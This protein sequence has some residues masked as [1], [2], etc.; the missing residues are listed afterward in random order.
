QVATRIVHEA[1]ADRH[2]VQIVIEPRAVV[3]HDAEEIC[4][5]RSAGAMNAPAVLAADIPG[6]RE[7][8][9]RH[10]SAIAAVT[11]V[12]LHQYA[13]VLVDA[14]Y[15]GIVDVWRIGVGGS[16]RSVGV[17]AVVRDTAAARQ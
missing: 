13:V 8:H 9:L 14:L 3:A 1:T 15:V 7:R 11:V 10:A 4:L 12:V 6:Q 2:G 5:V 17:S 16:D